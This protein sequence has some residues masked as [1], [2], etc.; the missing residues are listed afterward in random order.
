MAHVSRGTTPGDDVRPSSRRSRSRSGHRPAATTMD[1]PRWVLAPESYDSW[2]VLPGLSTR[3]DR[4]A[5]DHP[6]VGN[7]RLPWQAS[8]H[9]LAGNVRLPSYA[10]Y[11]QFMAPKPSA[12][13]ASKV[14]IKFNFN[15]RTLSV[16]AIFTTLLVLFIAFCPFASKGLKK[17]Q[18][19]QKLR[20][21]Q[22]Y[23]FSGSSYILWMP[24]LIIFFSTVKYLNFPY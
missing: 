20:F 23:N 11:L 9:P 24:R 10:D 18:C 2:D 21:I 3:E 6:L 8:D 4:Q 16:L 7:V 13:S 22:G 19:G 5:S 14:F 15:G 17:G 12:Q 1:H